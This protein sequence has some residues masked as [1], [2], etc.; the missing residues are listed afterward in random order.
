ML[1]VSAPF[2]IGIGRGISTGVRI[3]MGVLIGMSFNIIDQIAGHLG[4]VYNIN[5]ML[6]AML[7]S[8]LMFCIAVYAIWRV[9]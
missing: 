4:L 6:M 1:L 2:V 5:P 9:S 8:T 3:M 7:P